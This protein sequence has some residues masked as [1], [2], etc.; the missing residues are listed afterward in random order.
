MNIRK[1]LQAMEYVINEKKHFN[2]LLRE[3]CCIGHMYH[4]Y[5]YNSYYSLCNIDEIQR[6]FEVNMF[7]SKDII[8][9]FERPEDN[10]DIYYNHCHDYN[11]D[12]WVQIFTN[13]FNDYIVEFNYK[14]LLNDEQVAH[15][16]VSKQKNNI[17]YK[18]VSSTGITQTVDSFKEVLELH[19]VFMEAKN[20]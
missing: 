4:Y 9:F 15:I 12:K 14:T 2:I 11:V 1:F 7:L 13:Y 20:E 6:I 8:S 19:N 10:Q 16:L 17:V 3:H 5:N 18:F